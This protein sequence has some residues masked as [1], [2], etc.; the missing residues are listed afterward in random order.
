[1]NAHQPDA[2]GD[3]PPEGGPYDQICAPY[4]QIDVA[5]GG[6][7]IAPNRATPHVELKLG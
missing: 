6:G 4:D 5:T 1:M 3:G 7:S 2:T